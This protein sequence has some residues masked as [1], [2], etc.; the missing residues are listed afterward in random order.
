MTQA[1]L[2]QLAGV[3]GLDVARGVAALRGNAAKYL[4]LLGQFVNAHLDDMQRLA[5]SLAEG[6]HATAQRLA[7]TLKGTAATL[8]AEHLAATAQRLETTLRANQDSIAVGAASQP[9]IN[10]ITLDLMALAAVLP[11]RSI[12]PGPTDNRPPDPAILQAILEELGALL[13][14][15]DTAAVTHFETHAGLLRRALGPAC[16]DLARQLKQFDFEAALK[17]LHSLH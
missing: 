5:A 16:D 14:Q 1:A 6:D 13:T 4:D 8:G 17:T 7:H 15:S 12:E 9:E 11:T 3:P 2:A 10:A